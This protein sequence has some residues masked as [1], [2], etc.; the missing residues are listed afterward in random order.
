MLSPVWVRLDD[1]EQIAFEV[2]RNDE[3]VVVFLPGS[4]SAWSGSSVVV[5]IERVSDLEIPMYKASKILRRF[6]RGTLELGFEEF[7]KKQA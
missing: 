1:Y 7:P 6:G 3:K 2:E 5:D 4:P